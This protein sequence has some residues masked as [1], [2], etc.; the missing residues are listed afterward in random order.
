MRAAACDE[1][2]E[3]RAPRAARSG[4]EPTR[5]RN[6][7]SQRLHR[8][9]TP[10]GASVARRRGR[11]EPARDSGEP[12]AASPLLLGL[13]VLVETLGRLE[14]A[15]RRG[16]RRRRDDHLPPRAKPRPPML[17]EHAAVDLGSLREMWRSLVTAYHRRGEV[18]PAPVARLAALLSD[19]AGELD[20]PFAAGGDPP[21]CPLSGRRWEATLLVLSTHARD[22]AS[23]DRLHRA[24][25]TALLAALVECGPGCT[26]QRS[27]VSERIRARIGE[28]LESEVFSDGV[29]PGDGLGADLALWRAAVLVTGAERNTGAAW[30]RSVGA[31][32]ADPSL[33][34]GTRRALARI[35]ETHSLHPPEA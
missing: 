29:H 34:P 8:S 6:G 21:F 17:P 23:R 26:P 27:R 32:L 12:D 14:R 9:G 15:R 16:R 30:S 31:A 20:V 28:L 1:A 5:R 11:R 2:R 13:R 25:C 35:V 3:A 24:A 10:N 22:G 18:V 4:S 19:A 7:W 33:A